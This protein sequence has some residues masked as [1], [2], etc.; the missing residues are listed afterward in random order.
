MIPSE[1]LSDSLT[2]LDIIRTT[3][4]GLYAV[5]LHAF[6]EAHVQKCI[7][8]TR[9][10][11]FTAILLTWWHE[12]RDDVTAGRTGALSS[13]DEAA[14]RAILSSISR[15]HRITNTVRHN[16][17]RLTPEEARGVTWNF[18]RLGDYAGWSA[19]IEARPLRASLESWDN[20]ESAAS[21]SE[22]I[23][24]K[25]DFADLQR[26]SAEL[27]SDRP[28]IESKER[29]IQALRKRLHALQA[30][31]DQPAETASPSG[32]ISRNGLSPG[33]A[34][35]QSEIRRLRTE[36]D[37]SDYKRYI[38]GL[39]RFSLT[40][41]T[42]RDFEK[43]LIRLT[44]EQRE[45]LEDFNTDQHMLITGG[46]GTGKTLVL[47][48]ALS[49]TLKNRSPELDM[50]Q[51]TDTTL[52][53]F[54]KTLLKYDRY[55]ASLMAPGQLQEADLESSETF[56][57]KKLILKEPN[58]KVDYQLLRGLMN[59]ANTTG[60]L[61][62]AELWIEIEEFLFGLNIAREEYLDA[63]VPRKGL[64]TPLNLKE[65]E[66]VWTIRDDLDDHMLTRGIYSKHYARLRLLHWLA[67]DDEGLRTHEHL[68]VDES[69]DMAAVELMCLKELAG[70]SLIMAGD[71]GQSI[72]GFINPYR[73]ASLELSQG[74]IRLLKT[75]H[76]NTIPIHN[77]AESFR[78]V[79]LSPGEDPGPESYP[80]R[81]GPEPET[82]QMDDP[83]AL[84][85]LLAAKAKMYIEELGYDA[86]AVG[87]LCSRTSH[88]RMMA[89]KLA[90][91]GLD[92]A[93]VKDSGFEFHRRGVVRLSTLHSS[94]GLDFPIVLMYV[95][96]LPPAKEIDPPYQDR[97][98]RNLQYVAM[99]RGMDVVER[100]L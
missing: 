87:V 39:S 5:A 23:H 66:A 50:G 27:L 71:T 4:P 13:E 91:V 88:L 72:Y 93:V 74:Q 8:S 67:E 59:E 14:L 33:V 47:L 25:F 61:S 19:L 51:P 15:D 79:G 36:V 16:F 11:N 28:L 58:H 55:L 92:S 46:A 31:P 41:R 44:P 64:K 9:E 62:D 32:G 69:Q 26:R 95:P 42:R 78:R 63:A 52:V 76:R 98:Y 37:N 43:H 60:V 82:H 86:E 81:E 18:L 54:T 70:K 30:A 57:W 75:N 77:L 65:R 94:K 7:G 38:D 53:T 17:A 49:R 84:A 1:S 24:L 83:L 10:M 68:F 3:D 99:S 89:E 6:I 40:A 85:D 20:R 100:F 22:L 21:D 73:R 48:E 2:R 34:E 90:G 12:H 80:F 96:E 35:I 97:L 45:A 29:E 56:F